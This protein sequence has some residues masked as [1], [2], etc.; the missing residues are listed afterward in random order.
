MKNRR[1]EKRF[2]YA[3]IICSVANIITLFLWLTFRINPI[4]PKIE[5]LKSEIFNNE[6]EEKYDTYEN[7]VKD[8]NMAAEKYNLI[9]NIE[10]TSGKNLIDNKVKFD[11][12]L[13]T[14]MIETTDNTYLIK[15]YFDNHSNVSRTILELVS[16]Q[17][18]IVIIILFI[19]FIYTRQIVLKPINALINDI[20]NYKFGKKPKKRPLNTEFDLIANEFAD[21]TDRLDEEKAEQT[22][23]IASISHDIKTP[24]TSIIGYSNLLKDQNLSKESK[25]YNE[26][27]NEKALNIKD[28]LSTFDDYL[29]NQEKI[30][31]KLTLVQVKDIVSELNNDYKIELDNNNITFKVTTNIPEE[32][33]NVDVL[34]IKRIFSNMIS[35]SA[36]YLKNGGKI[37]VDI[38]P[39]DEYVKFV[40]KDNGPGVNEKIIDKIFD[41][42]FTTDNSRKISG[43]GLSICKEFIEMHDGTLKAYN[44]HG[45]TLEFLI[46]KY[47]NEKNKGEKKNERRN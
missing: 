24:L 10:D 21:L 25:K 6:I 46:P 34:K 43:L 9:I 16:I 35:N 42:L 18:I 31:L 44:D 37:L 45:L 15:I 7:M 38:S 47:K 14:K 41:P 2:I 22:R 1:L 39:N 4:I 26:K 32:Y 30:E 28:I 36:R 17:I 40:V 29:L 5:T 23:I 20:R 3:V 13:I 8:I 27:I 11:V 33:L 12:P 19:T